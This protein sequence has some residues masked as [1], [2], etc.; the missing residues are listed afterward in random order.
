[1]TQNEP[2][3]SQHNVACFGGHV[4]VARKGNTKTASIGPWQAVRDILIASIN[5]G[6]FLVALAGLICLTI[7]FRMPPQD[8]SRLV[9]RLLDIA[10]NRYLAGYM[11]AATFLVGWLLHSKYQRR[12]ITR[13][14]QRLSG[15][16]NYLQTKALGDRVKSSEGRT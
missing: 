5:K 8:L 14:L 1:M 15:E 6:Q 11:L 12:Q 9:F 4:A 10:E 7:V 16:R 3:Y 2:Y 13:E